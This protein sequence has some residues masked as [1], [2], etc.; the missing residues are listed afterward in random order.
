MCDLKTR[1][2]LVLIKRKQFTVRNF[3]RKQFAAV[4]KW[5]DHICGFVARFVRIK[6]SNWLQMV[7]INKFV[8]LL[9]LFSKSTTES[10]DH[11][12]VFDSF[13]SLFTFSLSLSL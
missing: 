7:A 12:L 1:L 11:L 4:H 5:I 8:F 3:A 6:S 13:P 10:T 2:W 9:V